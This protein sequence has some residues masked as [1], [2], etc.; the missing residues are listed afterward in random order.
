MAL[1]SGQDY[2]EDSSQAHGVQWGPLL[3]LGQT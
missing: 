1:Q 2:S 3:K